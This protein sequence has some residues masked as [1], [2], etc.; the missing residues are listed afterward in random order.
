MIRASKQIDVITGAG[1]ST[2]VGIP[3]L[4]HL[5]RGRDLS[6]ETALERDPV[7]FYQGFHQI[8]IDPIFQKGPSQAHRILADWESRGLI[9][10]IVT[11]NV[12]YLHELAGSRAV[13]DVWRNLNVNYCLQCGRQYDLKILTA[14][15]PH[16]PHCGG[17]ISPAPVYHH[18][19]TDPIA[20]R[21]ADEW[22]SAA[23]LVITIGS[24][25]YYPNT[26]TAKILDINPAR[27][28]FSSAADLQ[29]KMTADQALTALDKYLKN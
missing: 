7:G 6:S 24:N 15:V 22:M 4:A 10:G 9:S 25:G 23:D 20:V 27:D 26:G 5:P 8:F 3:D 16:C 28:G 2:T 12:D 11:T 19:A 21:Q 29:L 14:P 13:A 1:I 18:I 17:L